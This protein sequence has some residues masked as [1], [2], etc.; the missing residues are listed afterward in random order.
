MPPAVISGLFESAERAQ[1][2]AP[3]A[4]C[5][6]SFICWE[7]RAEERG[8]ERGEALWIKCERDSRAWRRDRSGALYSYATKWIG[9]F[10]LMCATLSSRATLT[11]SLPKRY[12]AISVGVHVEAIATWYASAIRFGLR[13]LPQAAADAPAQGALPRC[14]SPSH[15]PA[16]PPP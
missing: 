4:T 7:G 12:S 10:S 1:I 14:A 2:A 13:C 16:L 8:G 6:S 3:V 11:T 15:S 9:G 5:S